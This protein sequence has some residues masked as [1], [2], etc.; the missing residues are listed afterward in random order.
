M[1]QGFYRRGLA[2]MQL[3]AGYQERQAG[4]ATGSAERAE[5]ALLQNAL[6]SQQMP[7]ATF[8]SALE[9]ESRKGEDSLSFE[10]F[11]SLYRRLMVAMISSRCRLRLR[12]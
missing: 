4:C 7:S 8:E 10:L 2:R 1:L 11:S 3:G 6:R 12:H 9:P 5:S